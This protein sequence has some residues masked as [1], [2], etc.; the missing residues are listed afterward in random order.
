MKIWTCRRSPRSGSR[1]V[2]TWI[3]NVNG[4]NRLSNFWNF[5]G[6]IQVTFC[7]VCW[8][9]TKPGYITMIRRPS[10]NHASGGIA[11]HPAPKNSK[12]KYP[13]EKFSPASIFWDQ[14]G[15][16]PI[17]YLRKGQTIN[18]EYYLSLLVQL[19]DILREKRR[20]REGNQG[21]CSYTTSPCLT[22]HLQPTRNWPTWA[23]SVMI[24]HSIL[25][26][27]PRRSTTCSLDSKNN[28]KVAIF[29]PTRRTLLPR[30]PGWTDKLLNF[31]FG[32]LKKLE[33]WAKKCIELRGEYVE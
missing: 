33:R 19:K 1:N 29:L 30:R 3:K 8:P 20:P 16:L 10:H 23:S 21:S 2:W 5:F 15:I 26:I 31:F 17:D 4:S 12:C 25:R 7:R 6:R 27:W 24:T 32:G 18:A 14:D 9:W 28:W 11:A 13:L 22:G